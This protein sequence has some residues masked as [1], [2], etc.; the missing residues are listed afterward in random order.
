MKRRQ[1]EQPPIGDEAR[2]SSLMAPNSTPYEGCSD[3]E[4]MRGGDVQALDRDGNRVAT[5]AVTLL[6]AFPHLQGAIAGQ[7]R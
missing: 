7:R 6:D 3:R 2:V 5:P 4:I 1:I